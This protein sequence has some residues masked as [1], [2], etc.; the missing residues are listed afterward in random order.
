MEKLN[1]KEQVFTTPLLPRSE[2]VFSTVS[3]SFRRP[4]LL[5]CL[6]HSI[7]EEMRRI[8][9]SSQNNY[10]S[11]NASTSEKRGRALQISAVFKVLNR[12]GS[13]IT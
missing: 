3:F 10:F 13:K 9:K 7:T 4:G 2:Y 5:R 1:I 6:W 8:R 12:G 11:A